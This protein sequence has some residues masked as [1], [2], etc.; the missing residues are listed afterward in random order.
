[1]TPNRKITILNVDD[2]DAGRY[3]IS[4]TLQRSGFQVK[5][6]STGEEALRMAQEEPDLILLDV[7]LLGACRRTP[8]NFIDSAH[9]SLKIGKS[10]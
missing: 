4:K 9:C 10:W 3:A 7:N 8:K 6:A 5:E 2:D 1:M